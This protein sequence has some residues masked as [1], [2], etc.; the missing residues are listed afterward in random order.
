MT[1]YAGLQ[2]AMATPA[3]VNTQLRDTDGFRVES[4]EGDVGQVEEVW[5]DDADEPCALALRT[6]DGRHAL[7]LGQDVITVD[8]DQRWVVVPS[9]PPL[10]ELASPHLVIGDGRGHGAR[11]EAT[12]STTGAAL[13]ARV[14]RPSR[15]R[16]P[17]GLGQDEARQERAERPLWQ[18]VVILYVG[19]TIF[20]ILLMALAFV[21]GRLAGGTVPY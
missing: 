7:L 21:I 12:W 4:P 13:P 10:Q 16:L 3:Q 11:I 15:W 19:I 5:L 18:A 17:I 6:Q 20:V 14:G 9:S 1:I 2:R 8:R